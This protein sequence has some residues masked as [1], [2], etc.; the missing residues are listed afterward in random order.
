LLAIFCRGSFEFR[1]APVAATATLSGLA[2][3]GAKR[4]G[5]SGAVAYIR[6]MQTILPSEFKRQMVVMLDGSPHVI[7][8]MH[9]SRHRPDQTQV[10]TRLRH[11]IT[12]RVIDRVFAERSACP[13]LSWKPPRYLRYAQGD[14]R[15]FTDI[16]TFDEFEFSDEQLG[17]RRWFL[18][19]TRSIK[20]CGST[21][22]CSTSF[23]LHRYRSR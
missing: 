19:R 9:T 13:W 3:G 7:E 8:D 20:R 23:C 21:A 1:S 18:K 22:G 11:L 6:A 15:I 12:G 5:S 17:E 2:G 14:T 16:E 10:H 4:L